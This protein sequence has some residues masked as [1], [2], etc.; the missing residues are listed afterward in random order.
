MELAD[1]L[2]DA[3]IEQRSVDDGNFGQDETGR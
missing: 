1:G 2:C 3:E